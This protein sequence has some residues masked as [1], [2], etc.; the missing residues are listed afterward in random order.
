LIIKD[1]E[2]KTTLENLP[3]GFKFKFEV[4]VWDAVSKRWFAGNTSQEAD[5]SISKHYKILDC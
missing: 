4:S 3:I 5:F 2:D 1:Y